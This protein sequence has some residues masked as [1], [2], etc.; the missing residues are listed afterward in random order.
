MYILPLV[1]IAYS[2][3]LHLKAF[4]TICT[5]AMHIYEFFYVFQKK[6][7]LVHTVSFCL[8]NRDAVLKK[9]FI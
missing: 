5:I 2:F 9:D 7:L 8:K 1:Q 6:Y 3:I 4:I